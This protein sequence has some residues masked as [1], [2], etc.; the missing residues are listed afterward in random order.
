[1]PFISI[2][3]PTYNNAQLAAKAVE[4]VLSQTF[5]DFECIIT[6]DTPDDSVTQSLRHYLGDKRIHYIK[7][8]VQLGSPENWNYAISLASGEYIKILHHDDFF[9]SNTSLQKFVDTA[10]TFPEYEFIISNHTTH[11]YSSSHIIEYTINKEDLDATIKNPEK[12]LFKNIIG[13][14]SVTMISRRI[15]EEYDTKLKWFV[16]CEYYYR[17][18]QK[19]DAAHINEQLVAV[20]V[21]HPGQISN[22]IQHNYQFQLREIFYCLN[23]HHKNDNTILNQQ[24]EE[25][26]SQWL[27]DLSALPSARE[28]MKL[29]IIKARD[30]L[31]R[32]C[33]LPL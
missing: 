8:D 28:L 5:S 25:I 22:S 16:D 26:I 33:K 11:F 27:F 23:K 18:M 12:T 24:A 20:H 15:H 7:N 13:N 29:N 9:S 31:R 2:C 17:I 14:P 3:I 10:I 19:T 1:M 30:I 4:S 32:R 21:G 6:D